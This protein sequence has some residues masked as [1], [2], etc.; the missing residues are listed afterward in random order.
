MPPAPQVGLS[1]NS[2]I[3]FLF[4]AACWSKVVEHTVVLTFVPVLVISDLLP[5]VN[6]S[7]GVDAFGACRLLTSLSLLYRCIIPRL[8]P[9]STLRAFWELKIS[10]WAVEL[11]RC[12]VFFF[13]FH[14]AP[15]KWAAED[16][17][18]ALTLV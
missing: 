7:V 6:A 16:P 11:V 9:G 1:N 2:A 13:A 15:S 8:N 4:E 18:R 12:E 14:L 10:L 3:K 5:R 17:T